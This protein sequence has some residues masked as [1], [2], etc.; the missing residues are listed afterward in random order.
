[1]YLAKPKLAWGIYGGLSKKSTRHTDRKCVVKGCS[2]IYIYAAAADRFLS[3]RA[4]QKK[5]NNKGTQTDNKN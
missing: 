4:D 2:Y 5:K 3:Y 1:M